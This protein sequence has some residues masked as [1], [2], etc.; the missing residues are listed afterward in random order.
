[1]VSYNNL[2]IRIIIT[3]IGIQNFAECSRQFLLI[4]LTYF[5]SQFQLIDYL[6]CWKNSFQKLQNNH[7]YKNYYNN[8]IVKF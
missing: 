8:P 5:L 6:P 2:N 3:G 4:I 7:L 1:M